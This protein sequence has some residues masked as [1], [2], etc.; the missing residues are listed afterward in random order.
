M[1]GEPGK[2]PEQYWNPTLAHLLHLR[3][4]D[5]G[6]LTPYQLFNAALSCEGD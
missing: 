1:F 5:I 6:D 4:K 2:P 3:P